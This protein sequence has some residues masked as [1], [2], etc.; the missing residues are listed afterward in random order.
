MLGRPGRISSAL[1]IMLDG[2]IGAASFNNEFGRPNIL[3]YF[4]TFEQQV[5]MNGRSALRGY[6]KPIMIA[7]GLGNIRRD[8]VEKLPISPG[9]K[10]IV[11]GG[12]ALLIGL[13]GG[14]ASSVGAG[15]SSAGAGFCLGPAWQPEIQR[16]PGEVI[17]ACWGLGA[18]NRS[19]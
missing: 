2:P 18:D 15:A 17:D 6:H 3:G 5:A 10:I 1:E 7:G 11:L 14:A 13:G 12:P 4:R 8:H 19:R 9:A 16:G